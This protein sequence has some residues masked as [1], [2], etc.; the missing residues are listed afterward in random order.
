MN[1]EPLQYASLED[2][3]KNPTA[4]SVLCSTPRQSVGLCKSIDDVEDFLKNALGSD[5]A[6]LEVLSDAEEA[7]GDDGAMLKI[8]ASDESEDRDGD[9]IAAEGWDVSHYVRNPVI[10]W[11][12]DRHAPPVGR[13]LATFVEGGKLKQLVKFADPGMSPSDGHVDGFV[14]GQMYAK[15]FLNAFSVGFLPKEWVFN[16][17]RGGNG[18]GPPVDFKAQE[19]LE[20]SAVTVP[21]NRNA[22]AEAR[23]FGIDTK[24]LITWAERVLDEDGT[25]ILVPRGELEQ[26][27]K[28]AG[29]PIAVAQSSVVEVS[30]DVKVED[31]TKVLEEVIAGAVEGSKAIVDNAGLKEPHIKTPLHA[32]SLDEIVAEVESRGF[33]FQLRS[34]AQGPKPEATDDV[35]IEG[36]KADDDVTIDV[37]SL[38]RSA[39][40]LGDAAN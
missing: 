3:K 19:L 38:V 30:H 21:S 15:G 13:A 8:T 25:R 32:Y 17:E 26:L 10:L 14:I 31:P 29:A 34:K 9:T 18:F 23:S 5:D 2:W 40:S 1:R 12:H 7:L 27:R 24:S 39:L 4:E 11:G 35:I 22:L 16:E 33:E 28:D 36:E 37:V 6:L 20:N